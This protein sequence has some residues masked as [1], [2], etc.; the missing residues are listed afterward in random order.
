MDF[1]V[2]QGYT[3]PAL[4]DTT[5]KTTKLKDISLQICK[6]EPTRKFINKSV[7]EYDEQ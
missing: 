3:L 4:S 6:K 5:L 7:K 2:E 1:E